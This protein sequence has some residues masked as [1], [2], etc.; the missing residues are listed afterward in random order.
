MAALPRLRY[1]P[2]QRIDSRIRRYLTSNRRSVHG[3]GTKH[4]CTWS[5]S[6]RGKGYRETYVAAV[7]SGDKT[8][9][10]MCLSKDRYASQA[11]AGS[12]MARREAKSGKVLRLYQCPYCGG[13]HLTSKPMATDPL[14]A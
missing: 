6:G 1:N 5:P 13:Y 9:I 10:G 12:A 3:R 11:S 8:R 2:Y 7:M 4:N 14:A